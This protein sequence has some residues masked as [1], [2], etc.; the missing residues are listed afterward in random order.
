M[1][2]GRFLAP[3]TFDQQAT[4]ERVFGVT[5]HRTKSIVQRAD[6]GTVFP[7]AER[8]KHLAMQEEFKE[9]IFVDEWTLP[10]G[11]FKSNGGSF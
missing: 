5:I 4:H 6:K 7:D 1:A 11:A 8:F 9:S 2:T 10:A 3:T